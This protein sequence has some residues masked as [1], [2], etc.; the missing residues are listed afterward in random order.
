[1][2]V[3]DRGR[4]CRASFSSCSDMEGRLHCRECHGVGNL[5]IGTM[6]FGV[7]EQIRQ[8]MMWIVNITIIIIQF[9]RV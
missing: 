2:V 8:W 6:V 5:R 9:Y 7:S 4:S 1:M 3:I